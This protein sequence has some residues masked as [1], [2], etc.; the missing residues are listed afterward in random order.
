MFDNKKTK[1]IVDGVSLGANF[2]R[3]GIMLLPENKTKQ[4]I[5][6]NLTILNETY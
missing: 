5:G 6:I 1:E 3:S 4:I 2:Q